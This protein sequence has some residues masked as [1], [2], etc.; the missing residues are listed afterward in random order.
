ML[1]TILQILVELTKSWSRNT[2]NVSKNNGISSTIHKTLNLDNFL[3]KA[4]I[5]ESLSKNH[6]SLHR[7]SKIDWT[8]KLFEYIFLPPKSESEQSWTGL[9]HSE[10]PQLRTRFFKIFLGFLGTLIFCDHAV[11]FLHYLRNSN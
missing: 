1:L 11:L 5:K 8:K 7:S 6:Y 10:E 2:E 9:F 3:K 4:K